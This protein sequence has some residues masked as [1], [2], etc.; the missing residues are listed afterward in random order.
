MNYARTF[1]RWGNDC[2]EEKGGMNYAH[3]FLRCWSIRIIRNG[4]IKEIV[5]GCWHVRV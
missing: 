1:L 4:K 2:G 3:T 5:E